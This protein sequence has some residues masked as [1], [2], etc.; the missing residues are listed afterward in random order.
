MVRL[1]NH[2]EG[3]VMKIDQLENILRSVSEAT[4]VT[5]IDMRSRRR[6]PELVKARAMFIWIA[7]NK[8]MYGTPSIGEALHK[9]HS[10]IVA[11]LKRMPD[12]FAD[13][14]WCMQLAIAVETSNLAA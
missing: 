13:L 2:I 3:R 6:R 11:Q 12:N 10:T 5:I 9:D 1:A 7:Y 14:Q 4:G 8:T